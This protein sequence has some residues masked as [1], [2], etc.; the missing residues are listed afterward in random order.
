MSVLTLSIAFGIYG[1]LAIFFL[2]LI[3]SAG[4]A[5][6]TERRFRRATRRLFRL[7]QLRA[8]HGQGRPTAGA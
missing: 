7:R 6:N 8:L 1:V 4:R 2:S 5:D 3:L